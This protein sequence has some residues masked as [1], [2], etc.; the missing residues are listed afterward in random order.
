MVQGISSPQLPRRTIVASSALVAVIFS[1]LLTTPFVRAQ[2]L[3]TLYSFCGHRACSS[4]KLPASLIQATDG[5]F[6]G[7]AYTGGPNRNVICSGNQTAAGCGTLF[8]ITPGG[9]LTTLYAFCSEPD[10]TDGALPAASLLQATNG[11]LYGTTAF[12]GS[13]N[14]GTIFRLSPSGKLTTLYEFCSQPGCTDGARPNS[15]LIQAA[16][17]LLYGTTS[18]DGIN[19]YGT[20]FGITPRGALTTLYRFCT[21]PSCTDGA[22][23]RA[24]LIQATNGDLYGTTE[25]SGTDPLHGGT[26][27]KIT[28]SGKL[29]TL[30]T[31][32]SQPDCTDG[33]SP[34]AA[35]TQANDGNLYGTT[36]EGGTGGDGTIFEI[37]PSGR[38][39]TVYSFYGLDGG[40]DGANPLG[41]LTQ[42]T[43]GD[44]YGTTPSGG[45]VGGGVVFELT[46]SGVLTTLYNFCS[47]NP[48][49][50]DGIAPAG[51]LIQ[52]TNGTLYGTAS[53]GGEGFN[54][55]TI[56]ALDVG[57][58]AF[59]ALQTASGDVGAKVTILGTELT[60]ASSV[61]FN[62]ASATFSVNSTGTAIVATVPTGAT[63]GAV[64]VVTPNGT[65]QSNVIYRVN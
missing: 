29:T 44:L 19:T 37:T 31:F 6:Y 15:A 28:P 61:T 5:D 65:L 1:L 42:A 25:S 48:S 57:L 60:G 10:C 12:G 18:G 30:Y 59:V 27:F 36:Y 56:F 23:P 38:L 35:L 16:D 47:G 13:N 14:N 55:G 34:Q 62:G 40:V 39:T 41:T 63:T 4:G 50:P 20:V 51:T 64:Q 7:A 53:S 2:T 46:P 43:N 32:C 17:G 54:G 58:G 49:C 8:K 45:T 11:D 24:A 33:N 26:V 3:T 21:R 22:F 9:K 52:A